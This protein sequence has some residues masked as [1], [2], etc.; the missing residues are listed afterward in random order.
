M[1]HPSF[2]PPSVTECCISSSHT[3]TTAWPSNRAGLITALAW[4]TSCWPQQPT[5]PPL[6]SKDNRGHTHTHTW[7]LQ[8]CTHT[9]ALSALEVH[10]PMCMPM[11]MPGWCTCP[12]ACW[13]EHLPMCLPG[14]CTC[15]CACLVGAPA[16][17]HAWLVHLP[18]C[19]PG[20][21]TCPC[22]CLVGAP[23]HVPAWL[24]HLPMCLP[25]WCTPY[26]YHVQ[27]RQL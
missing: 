13:L 10:L 5:A 8:I 12:C 4:L 23:A 22:A 3:Q 27:H 21:C 16:H 25:G 2:T 26:N 18:M 1:S 11:C 6:M 7:H 9:D 15:P 19:L 24:V 14:W 20:W 17:V